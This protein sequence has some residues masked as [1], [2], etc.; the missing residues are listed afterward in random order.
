[1][2]YGG[3]V[4]C[5]LQDVALFKE[6]YFQ[7]KEAQTGGFIRAVTAKLYSCISDSHSETQ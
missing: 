6:C 7:G 5:L 1:M 3:F 2:T 4:L